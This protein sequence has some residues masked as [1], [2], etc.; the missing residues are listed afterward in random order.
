[1]YFFVLKFLHALP[2]EWAHTVAVFFLRWKQKL[3]QRL[4]GRRVMRLPRVQTPCGLECGNR[5]GLAAGFDKNAESFPALAALG[6]G[7]LEVGTVTPLPQSGNPKPRL[8]REPNGALVNRMGFNNCGL[9][10]F[11]AHLVNLRPLVQGIP[12]LANIGKGKETP[13]EKA[14]ED[15]Q[16]GFQFLLGNVDG[17]VVN[18]SSPN[19]PSLVKLQSRSFIEAIAAIAP[20][21]VPV[22][23]KFSPDLDD[24]VVRELLGSIRD[25]KKIRGVVLAN[26]SRTLAESRYPEGGGLSGTP[27]FRRSLELV[28][29]ARAVLG[30]QKT[31]VGVGG[32]SSLSDFK[33]MRD[34]GA[35]L[36]EIYTAFIYQGPA[37]VRK[38]ASHAV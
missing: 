18:V 37:L 21:E 4:L 30:N 20:T 12:I 8:F 14:I 27:L 35:D 32:V 33:Q 3:Y 6:F 13:L 28:K 29:M 34:A 15:Y 38:I 22:W 10:E 19:T 16:K 9:H 36:V 26:T 24:E 31:I 23:M 7:F 25:Q 1:M 11:K 5:L 17:F 2:P